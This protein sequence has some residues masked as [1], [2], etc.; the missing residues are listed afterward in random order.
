[1]SAPPVLV[2]SAGL[3]AGQSFEVTASGLRIGRDPGNELH[4]NDNDVSRFH[5]RVLL[6]NGAVW[7]QDAGSRN[8]VFVNDNRIGDNKTIGPG[9]VVAVGQHRFHIEL[10]EE[11][12]EHSVSVD[13]RSVS[14]PAGKKWKIWPFALAFAL[15][16]G[17]I[18]LVSLVS[19]DDT[20]D[21]SQGGE[22]D[23][24][25]SLATALKAQ[26]E[27]PAAPEDVGLKEALSVASGSPLTQ[28]EEWPDPPKGSTAAELVEL[29]HKHYNAKRHRDA[30]EHYQ[31]AYKLDKDCEI[32]AIRIERLSTEIDEMVVE[33]FE[34]GM[35]YYDS[36]QYQQAINAW[37]TVLMLQPDE[38]DAIHQQA[39]EH[40]EKA[41]KKI[42]RQY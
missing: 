17:L 8:G 27:D 23:G 18:G 9:D 24:P 22:A 20:E 29:G 7:V 5:A 6:H 13:L 16:I 3:L 36:L 41:R 11:P 40:L 19:G 15:L 12:A 30:L 25:V 34:A 37:E 10:P 14:E 4:L 33:N 1:M 38:G 35:R 26:S 31:M 21:L 42:S 2:C 39:K 28:Q 32:C